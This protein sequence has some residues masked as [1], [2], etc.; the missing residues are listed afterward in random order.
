MIMIV[1]VALGSAL[2]GVARYLLGI[3]IRNLSGA[4]FPYWTLA[5]NVIGS[6][7]IVFLASSCV[8]ERLRAFVLIGL[9]GGF[10]TFSAFSMETLRLMMNDHFFQASLNVV[11]SVVL[12]LLAAYVGHV[13]SRGLGLGAA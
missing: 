12:C 11:V 13:C 1:L 6:F 7:L 5:V 10:T 2:G 9:M 4:G 8:D 3:G